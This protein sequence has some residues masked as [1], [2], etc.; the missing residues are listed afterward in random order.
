MNT[1]SL[2]NKY[3]EVLILNFISMKKLIF[4]PMLFMFLNAFS[5]NINESIENCTVEEIKVLLCTEFESIE[6]LTLSPED[7]L[8]LESIKEMFTDSNG[9]D[10]IE[11]MVHC[12]YAFTV[13]VNNVDFLAG[14][15]IGEC[16]AAFRACR[17]GCPFPSE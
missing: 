7:R 10:F 4:L 17:M 16:T 12:A 8:E 6:K 11:C 1:F 15:T 2:L 5:M 9:G 13:C 14:E 3:I